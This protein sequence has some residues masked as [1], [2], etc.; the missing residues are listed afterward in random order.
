MRVPSVDVT[1][2][3]QQLHH[4][5]PLVTG[6]EHQGSLGGRLKWAEEMVGRRVGE[7]GTAD[8]LKVCEVIKPNVSCSSVDVCKIIAYY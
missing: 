6:C 2:G 8:D 5:V 7:S 1:L 3:Q 4:L